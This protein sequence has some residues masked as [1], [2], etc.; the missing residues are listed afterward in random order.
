MTVRK[1]FE[2]HLVEMVRFKVRTRGMHYY[3]YEV[4][5][6]MEVQGRKCV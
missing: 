1:N 2:Q 3:V 6:E 4:I 5:T